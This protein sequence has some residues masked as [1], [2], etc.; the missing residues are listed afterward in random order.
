MVNEDIGRGRGGALADGLLERELECE[1]LERALERAHSGRG[2]LILLEGEA[3]VGKSSLLQAAAGEAAWRDFA[4][5]A[6]RGRELERDVPFGVA[7]DLV[8]PLLRRGPNRSA[9]RRATVERAGRLLTPNLRAPTPGVDPRSATIEAV[10]AVVDELVVGGTDDAPR[11][12]L[13]TVDD[14]HWADN[15]SLRLLGHLADRAEQRRLVVVVALRPDEVE[16]CPDLAWLRSRP[17]AQVLRPAPLSDAAVEQLVCER[18]PRSEPEFWRACAEVTRGNPFLLGELLSA[19][20][21]DEVEGLEADAELA[22]TLVPA[23]VL[24]S[25]LA[26]LGPLPPEAVALATAVAVLGEA[27]L[28]HAAGLARLEPP[29]VEE[30][31]DLL[32]RARILCVGEPL[33]FVHPLVA[34]A[35]HADLGPFARARAHRRAAEQ[36]AAADDCPERV[37][38]HLLVTRPNGDPWVIERLREA[39]AAALAGGEPASAVRFLRRAMDE[40]PP[41]ALRVHVLL[42][43]AEAEA[44]CG[45]Q[46]AVT[47]LEEALPLLGDP[48][49]RAEAAL[50]LAGLLFA[51]LDIPAAGEVARRGLADTTGRPAVAGALLAIDLT[52][53]CLSSEREAAIERV[54]TVR[55]DVLTGRVVASPE[56]LSLIAVTA[57]TQGDRPEMVLELADRARGSSPA[58]RA[59]AEMFML[60]FLPQA[61]IQADEFQAARRLLEVS[62][63]SAKREGRVLAAALAHQWHAHLLWHEGHLAASAAEAESALKVRDHGWEVLTDHT[64]AVLANARLDLGDPDA[65]RTAIREGE[66]A[67]AP[68]LRPVLLHARGRLAL[69]EG[70][71]EA[72]LRDFETAG[73]YLESFGVTNPAVIPWRSAS[74]L[75]ACALG[76]REQATA[77]VEDELADARRIGVK[78]PL[79]VALCVAGVIANA[80]DSVRLLEEAVAVLA[81]SPGQLEHTRALVELGSA[82]RR[83]DRRT[84]AREPL[85]RALEWAEDRRAVPLAQRARHE[86]HAC[87]VRPRRSARS[88][89]AALTAAERRIAELA[90][91]GRSNRQIADQLIVTTKTVEWHLGNAYRKLGIATRRELRQ[92]LGGPDEAG[93]EEAGQLQ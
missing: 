60:L 44:R 86:L 51:R 20:V 14:A 34:S 53:A 35:V 93:G 59:V 81:G 17:M 85:S 50:K 24:R 68:T 45:E 66:G 42:E 90:A 87:G 57:S 32:S 73:R 7:R 8:A 83:Q 29:A 13:V 39:G 67:S 28:A 80:E 26:R 40:P 69:V 82:L 70:D 6:A 38:G 23:T 71:P 55:R 54:A 92:R 48:G 16:S 43:L 27:S 75:A 46:A 84:E 64:A 11:P 31:A 58:N 56:L 78:R 2:S 74:A 41:A 12:A 4:W 47:H 79:G 21:N 52:A 9:G 15:S 22:R 89:P 62:L 18:M 36:L 88:G 91:A 76:D 61:L 33:R 37:G 30:A 5:L 77:L 25:T 1:A 10:L 72:A 63:A 3:G 49:E 65:A 19:L